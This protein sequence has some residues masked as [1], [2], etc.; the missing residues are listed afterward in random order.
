LKSKKS[1]LLA[2]MRLLS[3][4]REEK[5][6]RVSLHPAFEIRVD[7]VHLLLAPVQLLVG[8]LPNE[9]HPSHHLE[10]DQAHQDGQLLFIRFR[11]RRGRVRSLACS[12]SE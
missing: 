9:E 2:C 12:S 3:V 1:R 6:G 4:R 5:W 10:V 7:R 11:H 8:E